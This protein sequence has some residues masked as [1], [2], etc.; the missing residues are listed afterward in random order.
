MG[1]RSELSRFTAFAADRFL[2][3]LG[4]T[5]SL[6]R[7][8]L[9]SPEPCRHLHNVVNRRSSL[10]S[11]DSVVCGALSVPSQRQRRQRPSVGPLHASSFFKSLGEPEKRRFPSR[12]RRAAGGASDLSA[13]SSGAT[14]GP[15]LSSVAQTRARKTHNTSG[16][17]GCTRAASL[18]GRAPAHCGVERGAA[19]PRVRRRRCASCKAEASRRPLC[20]GGLA[21]HR[22]VRL[23]V[24]ST[25]GPSQQPC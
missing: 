1:G 17:R 20:E 7:P 16:C 21:A 12:A 22:R 10:I 13:A 24:C 14:P 9:P 11:P 15:S 3:H 8:S 23:G 19:R 25:E 5:L 18:R 2:T 6:P 4:D